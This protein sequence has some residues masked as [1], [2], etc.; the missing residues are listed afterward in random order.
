MLRPW[1]LHNFRRVYRLD[2]WFRTRLTSTGFL[3]GGATAA[4]GIIGVNPNL[5]LGSQIFSLLLSVL[6]LAAISSWFFSPKLHIHRLLPSLATVGEPLRYRLRL[7]NRGA[8]F[9]R[10]LSLCDELQQSWPSSAEFRQ[11]HDPD[12]RHRN[13]FDRAVGYPKWL[14]LLRQ[15]RGADAIPQKL[16]D[17]APG[18][19]TEINL[20]LV[21][22]RRGYLRFRGY[23]I[24][25]PDPFGLFNAIRRLTEPAT[26]LVL[27]KRYS[28]SR[29][30][31]SGGRLYQPGGITL[32]SS[33]G[34]AEE[35]MSL[36]DYRPGDSLRD[37][38][39][40]S[41]AKTGKPIVKEKRPEYF[42]RHALVLDT[43]VTVGAE[44]LFEEAVAVA[45]SFA[46]T[47]DTQDSLL[48]LI[49]VGP[50]AYRFTAGHSLGGSEQLLKIL[51]CV[52]GNYSG[53]VDQLC[54]AVLQQ[55]KQFSACILVFLGWDTARQELV[56]SL[57][58]SGVQALV[59]VVADGDSSVSTEA[60]EL[61]AVI[62]P[63]GRVAERLQT[64][65]GLQSVGK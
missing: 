18:E 52:E 45:A 63:L 30:N 6:L 59:L 28:V 31:L 26:L 3:V 14:W 56:S 4:A 15:L 19:T 25:R 62:L 32:A 5:T 38:H 13:P 20:Q 44:A 61:G 41:W 51:A 58:R 37:I 40:R 27:P 47:V 64:V 55:V 34:D 36:R 11:R 49:F 16:P 24:A 29:P 8:K 46:C 60:S 7:E 9:Q 50:Q 33:R 10:G 57:R 35:F 54:N 21:P 65:D 1:L 12:D 23:R 43:F 39:W 22:V 2:S 42:T 53:K 17:L 48:D